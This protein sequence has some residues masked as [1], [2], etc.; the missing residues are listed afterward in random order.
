LYWAIGW[1]WDVIPFLFLGFGGSALAVIDLRAMRLPDRIILPLYAV[2]IIGLAA[3]SA[4]GAGWA[5]M[6][7]AAACMVVLY[8]L[9]FVI[10]LIGPMGGG[11]VKLAGVL[12]LYLGW[13]GMPCLYAGLLYGTLAAAAAALLLVI[14]R[15]AGRR[16]A[17]PYGPFLLGGAWLAILLHA[18]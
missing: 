6:T 8:G 1:H 7:T 11:D 18:R 5:P 16:S 4:L 13:L 2:G 10:G 14:T 15:R 3:A 17:L 9:F 12:G